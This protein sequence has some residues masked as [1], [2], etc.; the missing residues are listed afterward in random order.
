MRRASA[1]ISILSLPMSG[2]S[3]GSVA[4]SST[5]RDVL[6]RLR[7]HLAERLAGHERLGALGARDPLGDAHHQAAVEQHAQVGR[8]RPARSR[9]AGRRRARCRCGRARPC[10]QGARPISKTSRSLASLV[11]GRPE[12]WTPTTTA[13]RRIIRQVA[14]GESMPAESSETTSARH[15]DRQTT[16]PGTRARR[17][18]A[19]PA[20]PRC[21]RS[22]PGAERSTPAPVS[23]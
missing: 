7:G 4:A 3:T 10:A 18:S 19:R 22:R 2:R 11:C 13:P 16:A 21:A 15:A 5:A 6:E 14:T 23:R 17:R 20:R 8:A 9:A 1:M 12:K